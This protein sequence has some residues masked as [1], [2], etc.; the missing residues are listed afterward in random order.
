MTERLPDI[1]DELTMTSDVKWIGNS[2]LCHALGR[3]ITTS[4]RSIDAM[5]LYDVYLS[6]CRA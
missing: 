6:V 2:L 3:G 5:M 1:C 4:F